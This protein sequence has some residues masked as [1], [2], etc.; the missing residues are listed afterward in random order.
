MFF[1]E[2]VDVPKYFRKIQDYIDRKVDDYPGS[3][4]ELVAGLK[5]LVSSI[6]ELIDENE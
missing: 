5:Y 3:R 4:V 1:E 2:E 6:E